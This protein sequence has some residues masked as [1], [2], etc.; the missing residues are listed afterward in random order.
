MT[1]NTLSIRRLQEYSA[2]QPVYVK[3]IQGSLQ[4]CVTRS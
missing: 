2:L 4:H 3:C 1:C